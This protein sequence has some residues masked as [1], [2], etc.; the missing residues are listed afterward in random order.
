MRSLVVV[1]MVV[2]PGLAVAAPKLLPAS[3]HTP[4][5][6]LDEA[7]AQFRLVSQGDRG[8]EFWA[9]VEMT[10]FGART[11]TARLDF[12]QKGKVIG[13]AKCSLGREDAYASGDCKSDGKPL[14][15]KGPIEA[16]LIY[17]D[18]QEEKEY[19]V[20]TFK[21]NVHHFKGQ[22]E[23]WQIVPD[24]LLGG[25]WIYMG[26]DEANDGRYRRP[27][28]YTWFAAADGLGSAT[29]RCTVDGKKLPDFELGTQGGSDAGEIEAD[30]QPKK[31]DR[32]TYKWMKAKL[33]VEVLWGKRDTLKWDMAKTQPP[34]TVLGDNP[35]A[36]DCK[37]RNAGKA[38]RQLLFTVDKD[39]MITQDEIQTGKN[40]IPVV[41]PRVVFVDVR[42]TKDSAS[43]DKRIVPAALKKSLAFG[44]PWPDH[45][46]VKAIHASFP[47]K[48]GMPDP[49]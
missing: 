23:T 31:G 14:K 21:A 36:W 18:D 1:S 7:S 13:S 9:H 15:A 16:E 32:L 29:L 44:L 17:W 12:K 4:P 2:V 22:W 49:K 11:D 5:V 41:S 30:H 28:L 8:Y 3:Q 46:K 38:I 27:T 20:R 19:L 6:V 43:F 45:P 10:G 24:D 47:P 35:G 42:L 33:L 26:H 39:G 40:P 25:G 34:D 37:L 48:S